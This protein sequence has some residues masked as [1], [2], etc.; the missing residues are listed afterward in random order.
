MLEELQVRNV[1]AS[2]VVD[3]DA[4][5]ETVHRDQ[6]VMAEV[7]QE[8]QAEVLHKVVECGGGM[9][10]SSTSTGG[11]GGDL[12]GPGGGGD[13]GSYGPGSGTGG[14]GGGGVIQ[15]VQEVV[16]EEHNN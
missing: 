6:S 4:K 13:S 8:V 16:E 10:E 11:S 2:K 15:E 9:N 5:V 14:G 12:G 1:L 7:D 3:G